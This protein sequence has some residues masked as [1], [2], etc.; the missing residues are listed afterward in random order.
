M[1]FVPWYFFRSTDSRSYSTGGK[2]S[3]RLGKRQVRGVYYVG[4]VLFHPW[5]CV[6]KERM[7]RWRTAVSCARFRS[8]CSL[9]ISRKWAVAFVNV[10]SQNTNARIVVSC[11]RLKSVSFRLWPNVTFVTANV[12]QGRTGSFERGKQGVY[13][14]N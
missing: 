2:Y 9:L 1:F 11:S 3:V 7:F 12:K 13:N 6:Q 5:Y 10:G 14:C 8:V 4:S